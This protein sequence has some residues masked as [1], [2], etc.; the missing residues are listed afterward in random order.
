MDLQENYAPVIVFC[1]NRPVHF[2]KTLDAL[3]ANSLAQDSRLFVFSDGSRGKGD[4]VPVKEVR[5]IADRIDG[6]KEVKIYKSRTNKGLATSVIEG[7]TQIIETFGKVIVLEDD[8]LTTP[9]FLDIMNRLLVVYQNRSDIFSVTGYAPPIR[10]P[11]KYTF[12]FYLARRASSWGWGTWADRWQLADWG[13]ANYQK[14]LNDPSIKRRFLEGGNDLLPMLHKQ[15]KGIIDS[16]A[17]RWC[18]CQTINDAYGVYP[19]KSKLSNIGTDGSGTNFTF[20]TETYASKRDHAL[21]V[22][23]PDLK[24]DQEVLDA[25]RRFYDLPFYLKMKNFFKYG[26]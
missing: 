9:D 1:Y 24:P 19:V 21:L 10:I 18:L 3:K 20:N 5:A 22:V 13:S 6:F 12:D 16:W 8:I 4:E 17:I 11:Q 15:Q 7:V 26:I 25:F 14:L 23:E 2:N